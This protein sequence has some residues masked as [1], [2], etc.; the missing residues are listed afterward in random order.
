MDVDQALA[1]Q[2]LDVE[3]VHQVHPQV[4]NKIRDIKKPTK[5]HFE[6]LS[7]ITTFLSDE[8][9]KK[10]RETYQAIDTD[11]SGEIEA[12]ELVEAYLAIQRAAGREAVNDQDEQEEQFGAILAKR[13]DTV[14]P[15]ERKN[16]SKPL[17]VKAPESRKS[18]YAMNKIKKM[19][20]YNQDTIRSIVGRIDADGD[21]TISY[22]EFLAIGLNKE[23][24]LTPD[25]VFSLFTCMVPSEMKETQDRD[26]WTINAESMAHY[27]RQSGKKIDVAKMRQWMTEGG[28]QSGVDA[29]RGDKEAD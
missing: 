24:H 8:E 13:K 11:N 19:V 27:F 18:M 16:S 3:S 4:M 15:L 25:N 9:V 20:S 10:I 26:S 12:D 2:W 17:K 21:G 1:H 7:L 5:L 29:F 22:M 6:L 28:I 23:E 14:Q